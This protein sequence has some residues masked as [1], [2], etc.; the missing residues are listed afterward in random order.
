LSSLP[1]LSSSLNFSNLTAATYEGAS[2]VALS[3]EDIMKSHPEAYKSL[4]DKLPRQCTNCGLR[5]AAT[6]EGQRRLDDH[7][8]AHFRR[9][10]RL[11]DKGKRV[12]ARLWMGTEAEWIKSGS[13]TG[14]GSDSQKDVTA[15][16]FNGKESNAK[17]GQ[18]GPVPML[19]AGPDHGDRICPHCREPIE[20]IWDDE[21]D[22]WMYKNAMRRESD[23]EIIHG[24]CDTNP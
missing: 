24:S 18:T 7:L 4:Y 6:E 10:I 3:N 19:K 15:N 23:Q 20:L 16:L 8:D 11:K 14:E 21:H 12:M 5:F 2:A 17:A 22:E 1:Q 13:S 9:N